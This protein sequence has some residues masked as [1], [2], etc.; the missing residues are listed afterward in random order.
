MARF[1]LVLTAIVTVVVCPEVRVPMF[2]LTVPLVSEQ[3]VPP[4]HDE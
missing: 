1:V 4:E 3:L 2:Q